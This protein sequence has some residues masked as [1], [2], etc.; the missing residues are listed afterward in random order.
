[1][2]VYIIHSFLLHLIVIASVLKFSVSTKSTP[3]RYYIDFIS[4]TPQITTKGSPQ[5]QQDQQV[6]TQLQKTKIDKKIDQPVT[7]K[8]NI[9]IED[10]DY[11][12]KNSTITKPS[13]ADESSSILKEITT[14]AN[15]SHGSFKSTLNSGI[16]TDT[17]FPY[18]WYITKLRSTIWD[19]WQT[20]KL[21]PQYGVAVVRFKIYR[22]GS[23][24]DIRIERS[25]GSRLFDY[26][27]ISAI[28]SIKK[29][30]PLPSSFEEDYLTVY[31]E[32]KSQ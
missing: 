5:I 26:S 18:P 8:K 22:D 6:Q 23:I 15:S 30:E 10:P 28:N 11:L 21:T 3:K 9:Q 31:V 19:S 20:Q 32:F 17:D 12:Y 7:T 1:M 27:A 16:K 24:K 13:M 29:V 14:K 2:S 25:S 4:Q